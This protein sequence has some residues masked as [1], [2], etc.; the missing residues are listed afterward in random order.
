MLWEIVEVIQDKILYYCCYR[1]M[2][3]NI[4]FNKIM[5]DDSE[6]RYFIF[7]KVLLNFFDNL[8]N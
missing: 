2:I 8:N 1:F 5:K 6:N 3:M 7:K 4:T